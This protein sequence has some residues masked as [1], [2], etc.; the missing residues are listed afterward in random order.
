M[1]K[2]KPIH[3]FLQLIYGAAWITGGIYGFIKLVV[4]ITYHINNGKSI[5]N[6]TS[7]EPIDFFGVGLLTLLV[8][9]LGLALI[10]SLISYL[11]SYIVGNTNHEE[12]IND[13]FSYIFC[14]PLKIPEIRKNIEINKARTKIGNSV[15]KR[16]SAVLDYKQDKRI[17]EDP[18]LIE[19]T[20]IVE[21]ITKPDYFSL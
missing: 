7:I 11:I 12:K 9:I 14:L 8:I 4:Y 17:L 1:S 15:P 20:R 13:I 3:R 21:E 18:D 10:F 19:G 16:N 5:M 2:I 6:N